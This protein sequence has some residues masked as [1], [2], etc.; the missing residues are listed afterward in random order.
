V[1]VLLNPAGGTGRAAAIW[2]NDVEPVLALAGVQ[3]TL[4]VTTHRGHATQLTAALDASCYDALLV[5]SG[6]GMSV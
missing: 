6:D 3:A 5:V 1:A 4:L 2:R